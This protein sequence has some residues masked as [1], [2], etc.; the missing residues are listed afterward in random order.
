MEAYAPPC[1]PEIPLICMDEQPIQL[2]DHSRSPEP[3]KPGK[4][5]RE[6]YEYV[7]KG[8]CCLFL[9]T[10]PLAGRRHVHVS[11]TD[12]SRIDSMEYVQREATAW[13]ADRNRAQK[14]VQ[15]HFTTEQ[16]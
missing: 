7:R 3:V 16:A 8:S 1:D 11:M 15:W 13:E 6:D 9:F 5:R 12:K 4:V 14:S 2:L 10:E